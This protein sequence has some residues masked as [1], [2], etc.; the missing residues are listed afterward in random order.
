MIKAKLLG[1]LMTDL[2]KAFNYFDHKLLIAKLF[3]YG[4]MLLNLNLFIITG[5]EGSKG[6]K[7]NQH[8]VN[9]SKL[10]L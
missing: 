6:Q 3:A 9:G 4:F 1:D 2:S 8:I 7:L 5:L 10:L